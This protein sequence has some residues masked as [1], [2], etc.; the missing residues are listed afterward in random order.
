MA[1]YRKSQ[2]RVSPAFRIA[3]G[4]SAA[5]LA[6]TVLSGPLAWLVAGSGAILVLTGVFGYCPMC[7]IAGIG[8]RNRS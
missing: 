8:N 7:A 6:G 4:G 1:F 2:R 3:L 5:V